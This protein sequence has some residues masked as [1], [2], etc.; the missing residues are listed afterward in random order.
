M[1]RAIDEVLEAWRAAERA[2]EILPMRSP[3]REALLVEVA[4]LKVAYEH[5]AA[6]GAE[7]TDLSVDAPGELAEQGPSAV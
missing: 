3:E 6:P 1:G 2:L 5:L 4:R 7:G